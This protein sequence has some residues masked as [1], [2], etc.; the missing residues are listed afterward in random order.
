MT[1]NYQLAK[2]S[3]DVYSLSTT[4]INIVE[5]GETSKWNRVDSFTI[6]QRGFSCAVYEKTSTKPLEAVLAFRGTDDMVDALSDDTEIAGL[7]MPPQAIIAVDVARNVKQK[8]PKVILTGHSLGGALA[9]IAGAH[10][11]LKVVTFNAPGVLFGCVRSSYI[12][13]F[14]KKN[15]FSGL[16]S[17]V[18]V[19]LVGN[20]V[21]NIRSSGDVVSNP[22][23]LQVGKTNTYPAKCSNL[24]LLCK[25]EIQ[26]LVD[27][28]SQ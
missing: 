13:L 26:T 10:T 17:T 23:L 16:I 15:K 28:L 3:Q 22:I 11:G 24:N 4:S 8:Y 5:K 25:H 27:T 12:E 1:T 20:D 19:C 2:L 18:K 9:I 7:K 21:E 14:S 6:N